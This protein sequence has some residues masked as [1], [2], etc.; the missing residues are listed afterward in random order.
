[1]VLFKKIDS[2][3]FIVFFLI[4]NIYQKIKAMKR[5][6][7]SYSLSSLLI[8]LIMLIVIFVIPAHSQERKDIYRS[9]SF[10]IEF[11]GS[12]VAALTGN[13]DFRFFKGRND[14][15]GMRIGIGGES[16]NSKPLF[17]DGEI[18][19]KLFTVPLEV[20]YIL[21]KKRFSFEIGYSLTYISETEYSS[22][23][24]SGYNKT[25][26]SGSFVV[27][28]V[29]MGFRLKPKTDG[30]MLKFNLGPL[31]NYSAPNVFHR[32]KNQFW[33]GLAIGYSFY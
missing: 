7:I 10:F 15:I 19:I 22:L 2:G 31:I 8:L 14:G 1:M 27:S 12:G 4:D 16:S 17:G 20:N 9:K 32:D 26:Q 33:F 23:Q 21:G 13:Y 30:F 28:Y 5:N 24:Y 25:N 29:P 11:G 6:L 3:N 18:K